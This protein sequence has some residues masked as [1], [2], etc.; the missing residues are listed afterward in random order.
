VRPADIETLK[1]ISD[2]VRVDIR[3]LDELMNLVGELVIQRSAISSI[4]ERL[5][6]DSATARIATELGKVHKALDRKLKE[7]Q[8]SVLDVRM[9]PL[10][11]IF[12]K[13]NRVGRRLTRD[14]NKNVNLDFTGVDTELDK[15]IVEQLVDPLMHLVRNSFDHAI[16]SSEIYALTRC[17][18]AIT[19]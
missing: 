5:A 2:T 1:S 8:G 17:S 14:L 12:E 15:L 7:L 6:G 4:A 3:K 19:S 9:V 13:L 10:R 18:V 11:Q 16:E